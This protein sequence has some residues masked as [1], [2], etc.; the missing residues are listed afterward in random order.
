M[1]SPRRS[2][3]QSIPSSWPET[4]TATQTQTVKAGFDPWTIGNIVIGGGLGA[5]VDGASG[6]M[7]TLPPSVT[8]S[9]S[10]QY[11]VTDAAMGAKIAAVAMATPAGSSLDSQLPAAWM[12]DGG[13]EVA[14]AASP[15]QIQPVSA[16]TKTTRVLP[17]SVIFNRSTE[18]VAQ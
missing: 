6:A 10:P 18:P 14:T 4:G 13:T 9:V 3:R 8:G 1:R 2:F 15:G 7:F 17:A 12:S 5:I 16:Q 11:A